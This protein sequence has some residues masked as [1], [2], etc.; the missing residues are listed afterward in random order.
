M[1]PFQQ[2]AAV[3]QNF[4]KELFCDYSITMFLYICCCSSNWNKKFSL[5]LTMHYF[6][7]NLLQLNDFEIQRGKKLGVTIS[8]NN[9]RLFVGNIPKN[10]ERH[11]LFEEF[12]KHARKSGWWNTNSPCPPHSHLN[13][14]VEY[15]RSC[16]QKEHPSVISNMLKFHTILSQSLPLL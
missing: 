13:N 16:V 3:L 8:Y 1:I 5:N 14:S 7:T 4:C 6:Y 2:W 15:M 9:H 12:T 10:R 11:E